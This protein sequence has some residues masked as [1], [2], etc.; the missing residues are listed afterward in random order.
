MSNLKRQAEVAKN[1]SLKM[2]SLSSEIKNNALTAIAERLGE[3]AADVFLANAKDMEEAGR[4]GLPM[5]LQKRLLFDESKLAVV[6]EGLIRL[7]ELPDPVGKILLGTEMD[8]GLSLYRVSC[9]IGVIGI[10]FE[11][12]PDAL[13]QIASLCLKTSNAVFLKGGSEALHTNRVLASIIEEASVAAGIPA[14]WITLLESRTEVT[15]M[16]G[17]DDYIDLLIPRGSNEFVRYI[18]EHTKIAVLGHADGVCHVYVHRDASPDMAR[19]VVVD[20]KTQYVAVCNAAETLLIDRDIADSLLPELAAALREK[21]V[22]LHGCERA[23]EMLSIDRVTDWHKE[24]LDYEM[25]VRIVDSPEE[26]I[27]H[28]NRYG[29][30]H[31]DAIVTS[32]RETAELFMNAVDSGNV[33]WNSSTRFS[34]GFK[35]GF[36]AEVGVSTSK[37]HA[38]GPVGLE[39]LVTYKYKIYGNG[40]IVEDYASGRSGFTHRPI[41]G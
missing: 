34:D 3:R 4:T 38:R 19:R 15:E 1:A 24:Y 14:G 10:I 21:G 28:I 20:S 31:T 2:F 30:G 6:T 32:D 13:V 25:S 17:L 29:S 26:A 18:M 35:Y 5:P 7:T 8:E 16:L 39:G 27:E 22:K 23:A 9:P 11:S 12:R 40:Q 36:G 33:F 41:E 37:I